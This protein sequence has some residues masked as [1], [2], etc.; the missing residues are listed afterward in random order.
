MEKKKHSSDIIDIPA[1]LQQYRAKW[2]LFAISVCACCALALFWAKTHRPVYEVTANVLID[3]GDNDPMSALNLGGLFG[4]TNY[5]DDEIFILSSHSLYCNVARELGLDRKRVLRPGFM[6]KVTMMEDYP[7]DI[8]VPPMFADTTKAAIFF[9]LKVND[10][11]VAKLKAIGPDKV[12]LADIKDARLPLEVKTAYGSFVLTP[13]KDYVAGEPYKMLFVAKGY[14]EA[15]EDLDE[16]ISAYIANKKTHV[17]RLEYPTD[18]TAFGKLLLNTVMAK[19]DERVIETKT[20][21]SSKT[22]EFLDRRINELGADLAGVESGL[23]KFKENNRMTELEADA[24]FNLAMK[25]EISKRLFEAESQLEIARIA[26]DFLASPD[27]EYS[28]IPFPSSD[29]TA[30][31]INALINSYNTLAIRR[32]QLMTGAK[33]DNLQVR[34]IEKQLDAMRGNISVSLAKNYDN[35]LA[36]VKELRA[37][38]GQTQSSLGSLP[39][40]ER[41]LVDLRRDQKVKQSIYLLLLEKRE[42]TAVM[43]ANAVS[44]G[45]V[46]DE[47]FVP[48]KPISMGKIKLLAIA[49]VIGLLLPVIFLYTRKLLRGRPETRS[50]IE[51]A[52]TPTILGEISTSRAGKS[53]VV[54]PNST[55]S[56]VELFKLVRT[57]LQF[58]LKG[59]NHKVVMVT[60]SQ[61]GEGKSFISINV[62]AALALQ[63]KKVL[64]VG[65]DIRKPML[66]TY[67][68]L[69][70][71]HPGLTNY[72]LRREV[73]FADVVQHVKDVKGLDAVV[74]G[75]VPPNPA[76][77][78]LEPRLKD[79]FKQAREEYDYIIVDSAPVGMVSDSLSVADFADATI[80]VTRLGVTRYRDLQFINTL[81]EE[82]RLP[83]MNVIVNGTTATQ[84]YGYGY[85]SVED[86]GK[87]VH[88]TR[89]G[90]LSK[91]TGKF[92]GQSK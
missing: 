22:L 47:A 56:T 54:T 11:G 18:D 72:L 84:G 53:L 73:S 65:L 45:I 7:I 34:N 63:G 71:D 40:Q 85:G 20:Q 24:E 6:Q 42:E 60:S 70:A 10:K 59:E 81:A 15:A 39:A 21:Q 27:N 2:Y 55:S 58:V 46:V 52:I 36:V 64:L 88:N 5:V 77:L 86:H 91:L 1:L 37:K 30:T 61:S 3:T 38:M 35:T 57:N 49:L 76:E 92:K 50:E 23:Q 26:R 9:N 87:N 74:A 78:L 31:G 51:G 32:L 89:R 13:T 90:I 16:N 79:F 19:Y 68:G 67:L 25:G 14:D 75:L 48:S 12:K 41:Q 4:A 43:L 44:K 28:M 8:I 83:K 82:E 80:Y 69:P 33:E 17:I 29:E 62:A 66:T